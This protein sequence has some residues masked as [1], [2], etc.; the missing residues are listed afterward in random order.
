MAALASFVTSGKSNVTTTDDV[1]K[2]EEPPVATTPAVTRA[3]ATDPAVRVRPRKG[4]EVRR[5]TVYLSVEAYE[6]LRDT[7]YQER[8]DISAVV[9]EAVRRYLGVK[10]LGD[11]RTLQR[12]MRLVAWLPMIS[13]VCRAKTPVQGF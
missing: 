1:K 3:P 10:T 7:A 9:D 13:I 4:G 2:T 8:R 6:G 12:R 11:V 5:T